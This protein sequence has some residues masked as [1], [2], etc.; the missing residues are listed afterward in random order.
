MVSLARHQIDNLQVSWWECPHSAAGGG[1]GLQPPSAALPAW[2]GLYNWPGMTTSHTLV[3]MSTDTMSL[4]SITSM[5]ACI[6]SWWSH[7]FLTYLKSVFYSIQLE[8]LFLLQTPDGRAVVVVLMGAAGGWPQ[9]RLGQQPITALVTLR[10]ANERRRHIRSRPAPASAKGWVAVAAASSS[11]SITSDHT[12]RGEEPGD[13]RP[14]PQEVS[15]GGAVL[16]PGPRGPP[17]QTRCHH[18]PRSLT[19]FQ[20]QL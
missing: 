15:G 8:D 13:V 10:P 16:H 11:S 4:L 14:R 12:H 2:A 6:A 9:W 17:V 3:P 20:F 19:Y 1:L 18:N 7:T 5:K